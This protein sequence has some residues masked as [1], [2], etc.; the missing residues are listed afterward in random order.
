MPFP[1]CPE[2]YLKLVRLE[3]Q[4]FGTWCLRLGFSWAL[5]V[6]SCEVRGPESHLHDSIVSCITGHREVGNLS[7]TGCSHLAVKVM[8]PD[9]TSSVGKGNEWIFSPITLFLFLLNQ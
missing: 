4:G 8:H 6:N 2:S 5:V 7:I 1:T 3:R 9:P